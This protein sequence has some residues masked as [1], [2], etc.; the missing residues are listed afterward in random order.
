MVDGDGKVLWNESAFF[1]EDLLVN[2]DTLYVSGADENGG[3]VAAYD[4]REK[5]ELWNVRFPYRA[6][7]LAYG[8]DKLAVGAGKFET[9]EEG[10]VTRIYSEGGLYLLNP[11]NGKVLW[12]DTSMGYVRSL[13]VSGNLL[14]AGTGSSYF[15][16]LDLGRV[17]ESPS[18]CGPGIFLLLALVFTMTRRGG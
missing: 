3:R 2:G 7:V 16:V 1:V 4:L 6:K 14:A 8:A 5:K 12:K 9:R 15:Y 13:A 17:N 11:K 18:I 10:N